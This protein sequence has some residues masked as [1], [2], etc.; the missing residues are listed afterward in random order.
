VNADAS[1]AGHWQICG[2]NVGAQMFGQ[3]CAND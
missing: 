2:Q 3:M 1:D